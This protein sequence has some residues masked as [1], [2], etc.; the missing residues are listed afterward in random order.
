MKQLRSRLKW[1]FYFAKARA[2][3]HVRRTMV[4]GVLL[5]VPIVI[6]FVILKWVWDFI[7]GVLRPSIET[8][9]GVSFPGLGVAALLLLVYV[10]GLTWELDL[11]RR[12]L[13]S[14]QRVL[15]SLPIVKIV[16]APARQ[17][18]QS[19][20]GSGPSGF[21]R[22][23]VIEYP[24]RGTWMLGFLTSITTA[25][26]GV[27]MG[28]VY[29]PT[30]PTPNSGWVAILPIDEVYDTQMTVQDAMTMVLS[31]GIAT[32]EEIAMTE[33]QEDRPTLVERQAT[34]S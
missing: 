25:K 33:F 23:V 2:G 27:R 8:T 15:M 21:K 30:A 19:F 4:E 10:A 5:L 1:R 31:G 34:Q 26:D 32:P 24:R 28:V 9:T 16:Y 29:V 17:L 20:S 7:D 14:G 13:G 22:V 3:L 18:I 6:T 11:G 12:L